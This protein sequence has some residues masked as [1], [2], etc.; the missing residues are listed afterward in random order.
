MGQEE[1]SADARQFARNMRDMYVALVAEGFAPGEA[2]QI[3]GQVIAAS[4]LSNGGGS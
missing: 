4:I 1:A 2:L 3:V